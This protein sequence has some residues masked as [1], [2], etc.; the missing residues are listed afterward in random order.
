[1]VVVHCSTIQ[2][3]KIIAERVTKLNLRAAEAFGVHKEGAA[4]SSPAA[5]KAICPTL[6]DGGLE[7]IRIIASCAS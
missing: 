2:I 3:R 4:T 1:M 7:R 5:S 6:G